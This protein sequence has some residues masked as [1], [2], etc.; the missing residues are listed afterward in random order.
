MAV[1]DHISF[2]FQFAK[3]FFNPWNFSELNK[4]IFLYPTSF[5]AEIAQVVFK[6]DV[7][8]IS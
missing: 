6:I 4:G 1:F 7:T 2:I 5:G 8:Y 3:L